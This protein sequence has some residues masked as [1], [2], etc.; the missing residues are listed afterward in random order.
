MSLKT[1]K[2][3]LYAACFVMVALFFLAS[4]TRT[5]LWGYLGL[6]N[7]FA[8]VLLWI[9][10]ADARPAAVFWAGQTAGSARTAA[11]RLASN[12]KTKHKPH[13]LRDIGT[14]SKGI[15]R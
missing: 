13:C 7:A 14:L 12:P 2:R 11:P 9:C 1:A 10:L 4:Y 5:P 15:S 6:A 8:G 3:L